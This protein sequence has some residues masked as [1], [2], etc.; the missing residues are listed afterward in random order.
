[1][2]I[3]AWFGNKGNKE[4]G[5][6]SGKVTRSKEGAWRRV[7]GLTRSVTLLAV[8]GFITR[9]KLLV[10]ELAFMIRMNSK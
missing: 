8:L 6:E 2:V 9:I 1:M 5:G 10:V 7:S 3:V 4:G